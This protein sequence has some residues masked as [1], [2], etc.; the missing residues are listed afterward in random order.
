MSAQTAVGTVLSALWSAVSHPSFAHSLI[1]QLGNPA[2]WNVFG[3]LEHNTRLLTWLAG[4]RRYGAC[5]AFALFIFTLG[6]YRDY[7]FAAAVE[8]G[9]SV[10]LPWLVS[11]VGGLA[12]LAA[13]NVLVLS[14]MWRLGVLGTYLGDHFGILMKG[15]PL[16][17]FPF[18]VTDHPMYGGA[19]LSFLGYAVY[20]GSVTGALLTAAAAASYV[21]ASRV[22]GPFTARLYAQDAV[23]AK[24]VL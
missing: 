24:R 15:G 11:T 20:H 18:S 12:L 2:V 14:S 3:R 4:G 7:A 10:A 16:R 13:G 17:G 22:E 8:H 9:K 19:T 21:V 6:L 5:Y 23:R 1:F